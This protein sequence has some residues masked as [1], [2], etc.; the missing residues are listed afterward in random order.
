MNDQ[1]SE[2]AAPV[3]SVEAK[4]AEATKELERAR[5]QIAELT[6]RVPGS[7]D[8]PRG[9]GAMGPETPPTDK[10]RAARAAAESGD[11]T[12]LMTY[13]RLKRSGAD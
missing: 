9:A 1:T 4:L 13:L 8:K 12:A 3:P 7:A 2:S 6:A 5:Q 11:R 10:A